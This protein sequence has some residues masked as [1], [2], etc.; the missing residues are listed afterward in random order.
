VLNPGGL[1]DS[2]SDGVSFAPWYNAL[3]P[4]G[5]LTSA[6]PQISNLVLTN[7]NPKDTNPVYGWENISVIVTDDVAVSQV[8][9]NIT[10]PDMHKENISMIPCGGDSYY[11]K[12][13]FTSVGTYSYFIWAIDTTNVRKTSSM[14]SY[15]KP[16]NWDINM[17]GVCNIFDVTL[18]STKWMQTGAPGW[19]REDINNDGTVNIGDVSIVSIY[20]LQSWP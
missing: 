12:T 4:G 13:T 8:R 19:I 14:N 16:P 15:I 20:W 10:Y 6:P 9:I 11:F 2:V 18:L 7:S 1:G 5:I 17:D 3:Y